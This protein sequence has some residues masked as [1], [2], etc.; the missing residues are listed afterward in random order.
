MFDQ[1]QKNGRL[2]LQ[3]GR[4]CHARGAGQA[5]PGTHSNPLGHG[6][7][8]GHCFDKA[9][10]WISDKVQPEKQQVSLSLL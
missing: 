5:F 8:L 3:Q 6:S 4:L 7:S 10:K 2:S 9:P 1:R